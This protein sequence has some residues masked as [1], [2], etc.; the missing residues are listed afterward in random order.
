MGNY[1]RTLSADTCKKCTFMLSEASLSTEGLSEA[2][3]AAFR[4]VLYAD[5]ASV[6]L[7]GR[8][9]LQPFLQVPSHM[10]AHSLFLPATASSCCT[11]LY[12]VP[13]T[14][15][16]STRCEP[17]PVSLCAY[18]R[19]HKTSYPTSLSASVRPLA[20][21]LYI[22]ILAHFSFLVSTA[23]HRRR[24]SS[25]RSGRAHIFIVVAFAHSRRSI[26]ASASHVPVAVP[27]PPISHA[28]SALAIQSRTGCH[29]H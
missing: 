9:F 24:S 7:E 18:L 4:H 5:C 19:P 8:L 10:T 21:Q 25:S 20:L 27:L 29:I 12:H 14:M 3:M 15:D 22:A 1:P 28:V 6:G 26:F 2:S 16:T 13:H 11:V 17:P 23:S